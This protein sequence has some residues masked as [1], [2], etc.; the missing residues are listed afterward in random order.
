VRRKR[1]TPFTHPDI[2]GDCPGCFCC[3]RCGG[4]NLHQGRVEIFEREEDEEFGKHVTVDRHHISIGEDLDD[5]PSGFEA[6][7]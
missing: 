7:P 2:D 6:E 5:N 4:A 1:T 3:P